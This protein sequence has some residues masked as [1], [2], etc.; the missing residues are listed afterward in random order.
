MPQPGYSDFAGIYDVMMGG[1]YVRYWWSWFKKEYPKGAQAPRAVADLA[2]GTGEAAFKLRTRVERLYLVD[3]APAMLA[4]ARVRL[5]EA[6]VLHA[7]LRTF[8]LPEPVD[9]ALCVFGGMNYMPTRKALVQCLRNVRRNLRPGGVFTFDLATPHFLEQQYSQ[10]HEAFQGRHWA[11]EW[12]CD[13]NA[14]KQMARI[15][16]ESRSRERVGAPWKVHI[17]EEH[18][19]YAYPRR[20]VLESLK[21]AGL[22]HVRTVG[23]PGGHRVR[24]ERDAYWGFVARVPQ[25]LTSTR[26]IR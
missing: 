4:Q 9:L 24:G 11:S 15:W 25:T 5:P 1:R 13:W 16:I 7:D 22:V 6:Q 12:E 8:T 23:L 17:P 19:H 18:R 26:T 14:R 2:C 3:A 21:Q 20:V 10:G